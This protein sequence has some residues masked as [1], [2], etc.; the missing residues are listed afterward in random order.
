MTTTGRL[1]GLLGVVILAGGVA[2]AETSASY[3]LQESVLNAGGDPR[4]GSV[5][6]WASF[7]IRLDAIGEGMLQTGLGSTSFRMDAGF[8]EAYRPP[9]EVL[10]IRVL[11]NK[12]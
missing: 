2:Q 11:P 10:N 12:Q 7:R 3:K 5:L 1:L 8:V 4:G 6:T 9:G